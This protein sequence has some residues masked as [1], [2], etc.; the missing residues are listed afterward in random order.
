MSDY[1]FGPAAIGGYLLTFVKHTGLM[2]M[3][4][5][6]PFA[7]GHVIPFAA[8][9]R[10]SLNVMWGLA[11]LA[12]LLVVWSFTWPGGPFGFRGLVIPWIIALA[13]GL[14]VG[15][16]IQELSLRRGYSRSYSGVLAVG[17]FATMPLIVAALA[18][19]HLWVGRAPSAACLAAA[20]TVEVAGTRYR[21]PNAPFVVM[22]NEYNWQPDAFVNR[23]L[24][25]RCDR[26]DQTALSPLRSSFTLELFDS[27]GRLDSTKR[28]CS[29]PAS[30][31]RWM[32]DA[33]TATS[34]RPLADTMSIFAA[35]HLPMKLQVAEIQKGNEQPYTLAEEHRSN[36]RQRDK[37][38]RAYRTL[39]DTPS[40]SRFADP[41]ETRF[42]IRKADGQPDAFACRRNAMTFEPLML[43]CKVRYAHGATLISYEFRALQGQ[44][45]ER[46]AQVDARVHEVLRELAAPN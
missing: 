22:P 32:R 15:C 13:Y 41:L 43:L 45:E 9:G 16:V 29:T 19:W 40:F 36:L 12:V 38:N 35:T 24:R 2:V 8:S 27:V 21:L 34:L 7:I 10:K 18:A 28:I 33:C 3:W 23:R 6:V 39:T 14:V 46:I 4:V 42:W 31:P 17:G 30:L 1:I 44:E 25:E 20:Q 5:L 26:A 37:L 11:A